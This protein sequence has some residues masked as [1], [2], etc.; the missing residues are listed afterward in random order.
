[1]RV[2]SKDDNDWIERVRV[3]SSDDQN[4]SRG[5]REGI[6]PRKAAEASHDMSPRTLSS[7]EK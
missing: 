3:I 2:S 5:D 7:V 6:G 1:M 4:S